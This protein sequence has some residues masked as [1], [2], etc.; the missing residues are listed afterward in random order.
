MRD[1][2]KMAGRN[3]DRIGL[4]PLGHEALQVGID[5][6]VVAGDGIEARLLAPGCLVTLAVNSV[7][8]TG[9]WTA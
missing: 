5:G 4:H 1:D 8:E 3:L 6:A 2:A 9:A 7:S